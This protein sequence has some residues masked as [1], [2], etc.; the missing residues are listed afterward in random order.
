M[1]NTEATPEEVHFEMTLEDDIEFSL[2][3]SLHSKPGRRRRLIMFWGMFLYLTCVGLG[4]MLLSYALEM[5]RYT[6]SV[7]LLLVIVDVLWVAQYP[8][9]YRWRVKRALLAIQA[10]GL[11]PYP[12]SCHVSISPEGLEFALTGQATKLEWSAVEKLAVTPSHI[13]FYNS[14]LSAFPV[15]KKAF[16][17]EDEFEHFLM[18][19]RQYREQV[20]G[21]S[22]A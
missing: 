18:T 7:G 20:L 17:S 8:R 14:P 22:T 9:Y 6:L 3:H 13:L 19:A 10:E 16:P 15:P 21:I 1:Q 2:Y 4:I 11:K 5:L 12:H